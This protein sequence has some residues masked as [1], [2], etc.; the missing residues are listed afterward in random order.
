MKK[1]REKPLY[2]IE[3]ICEK[4]EIPYNNTIKEVETEDNASDKEIYVN[5][6]DEYYLNYS[7][8]E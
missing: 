2:T 6:F 1:K 5:L 8:E 7:I 4:N 3:E